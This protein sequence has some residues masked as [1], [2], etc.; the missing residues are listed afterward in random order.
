M[1]DIMCLRQSYE[2]RV[3]MEIKYID[4]DSKP[5]DAMLFRNLSTQIW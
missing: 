1:V 5:A 3:I 2:R 4:G